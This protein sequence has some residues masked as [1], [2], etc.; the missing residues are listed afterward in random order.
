MENITQLREALLENYKM[1]K[2]KELDAKDCKEFSNMAGKIIA[3]LNV[4]MKYNSQ[5]GRVVTIKFLEQ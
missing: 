4:E 1:F 3:T 5:V 2:N